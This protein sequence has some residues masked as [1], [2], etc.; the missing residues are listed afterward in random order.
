M[1]RIKSV[2]S[3]IQSIKL[4]L[5]LSE[6]RA[7]PSFPGLRIR[8]SLFRTISHVIDEAW[9]NLLAFLSLLLLRGHFRAYRS[10]WAHWSA[11]TVARTSQSSPHNVHRYLQRL[12]LLFLLSRDRS[13]SW[14]SRL[15]LCFLFLML[16][17]HYFWRLFLY[18]VLQSW[19]R[20]FNFLHPLQTKRLKLVK[21]GFERQVM[22][23]FKVK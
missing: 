21:S 23:V 13:S 18:L 8:F 3:A 9:C 1:K 2:V 19:A 11:T 4:N 12:L 14:C 6:M 5:P 17:E 15:W 16:P 22:A 10:L 7:Y 20:L